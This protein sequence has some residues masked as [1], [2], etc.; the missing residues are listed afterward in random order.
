MAHRWA[1]FLAGVLVA[2]T[3]VPAQALER[4]VWYVAID[5]A[6]GGTGSAEQTGAAAGDLTSM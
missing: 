2:A 1:A 4:E 5:A 6:A 3:V